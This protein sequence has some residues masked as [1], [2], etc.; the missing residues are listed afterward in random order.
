VAVTMKSIVFR[1]AIQ[2]IFEM[3]NQ[4]AA[5]LCCFLLGLVFNPD[6]ECGMFL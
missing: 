1:V 4:L 2:R 3:S 5:C 6:N